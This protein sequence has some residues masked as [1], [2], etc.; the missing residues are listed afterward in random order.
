MQHSM[1]VVVSSAH[2]VRAT[3]KKLAFL[4]LED[5]G[6]ELNIRY[7]LYFHTPYGVGN[8]LLFLRFS[9]QPNAVIRALVDCL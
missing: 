9:L 6:Y 5:F 4:L 8:V 3:L 2:N 7:T 1:I